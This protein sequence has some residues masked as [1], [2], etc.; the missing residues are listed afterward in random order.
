MLI[1]FYD[2]LIYSN[3]VQDHVYHTKLVFEILRRNQLYAKWSKCRI[4]VEE[5]EYLGHVLAKG[6][7]TDPNKIQVI[8]EWPVPKTLKP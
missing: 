7:A 8:T 4:R 1:F 6:V 5:V 2:I 3:N